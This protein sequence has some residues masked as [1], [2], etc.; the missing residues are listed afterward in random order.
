MPQFLVTGGA[1]FIG[2]H[3]TAAL[4]ARGDDV[5]VLDDLSGGSRMRVPVAAELVTASIADEIA[6]SRLFRTHHFDGVFHLAAFAAEGISHAVKSL[7]YTANVLGSVNIINAA[8]RAEVGFLGFASSVAVYGH[9]QLPMRETD[10]AHPADSYGNAKLA[11]ER[12]LDI[13]MRL[14]GLPYFAFRMHNVYG[15]W[16]NMCDPYRNAVAIFLNQIMRGEPITVYG[17]GGQIRAFTYVGDIVGTFLVAADQPHAWGQVY[18]VGSSTTATVLQLADAVRCAM[19]VPAHPIVHLPAR[20]EVRTAYTECAHARKVL[21]PW[22]ETNLGDGI[23]RTAAWARE[24]GPV[25]LAS[26]V[27]I[28]VPCGVEGDWVGWITGRLSGGSDGH[29]P[30]TEGAA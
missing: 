19:G 23:A 14:Q 9:G 5:V 24:H 17:D 25:E 11:V 16:Q 27:R 29:R 6:V 7:N 10:V 21:G 3:L 22:P 20:E 12:E 4:V 15:E 13:T 2:S 1:G 26:A 8:L 28:E 18:N 30:L